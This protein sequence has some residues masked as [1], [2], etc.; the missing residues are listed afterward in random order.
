MTTPDALARLMGGIH[1]DLEY[2]WQSLHRT[3]KMHED[4]LQ[5]SKYG[6]DGV[7]SMIGV[8][9]NSTRPQVGTLIALFGL[10][11]ERGKRLA[12]RRKALDNL[13][14]RYWTGD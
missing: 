10:E 8:Y 3:M 1:H 12:R 2:M 9:I 13:L 14:W 6:Q 11:D 5:L 7:D 4:G